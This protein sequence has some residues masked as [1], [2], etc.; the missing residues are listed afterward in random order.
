MFLSTL[1]RILGTITIKEV[2]DRVIIEGIAGHWLA[3]DI[4]KVW[5]TSKINEHMFT[6]LTGSKIVISRFFLLEFVYI[7]EELIATPKISQQTIRAARQLL[8]ELEKSTWLANL[9]EDY[10]SILNKAALANMVLTPKPYQTDFFNQYESN[11]FRLGL[12]GYLLAAPPGSGK[13][14]TS[15]ALM[16]QL[17][18]DA[19]V[20]V[21][22]KNT[23]IDPWENTLKT[24]FKRPY[25]YWT[26]T[27]NKPIT[28]SEK[29][30]V[31]HY[32]YIV[33][34]LE[35]ADK[36]RGRKVGIILDECH[37]LNEINSARTNAFIELCK[38]LKSQHTLWMSGTPIKALGTEVIP[39]L[40]TVCPMFTTDAEERFKKVFG[41]NAKKALDIMAHRLGLLSYRIPKSEIVEGSPIYETIQ[42]T[43]PD[44]KLYTLE[45]I[46]QEMF[47]FM[48]AQMA[49]YKKD[50]PQYV[51][52]FERCLTEYARTLRSDKERADFNEYVRVVSIIR[53][54]VD[55][56]HM[57][58][59]MKLCNDY[60]LGKIIPTLSK[61]SATAFKEVR[62]L[63]KYVQLK[64]R[65]ECLGRV[66]GR[67]RIDCHVAMVEGSTLPV[68]VE[69]ALKK[70][71]IF[72]SFVEVV[73]RTRDY[74]IK[75]GFKPLVVYGDT[76]K[77]IGSILKSY[78]TN[79]EID[80]LIATYKSL[81]TGVPVTTANTIVLMNAPFR[82]YEKEQAISRSFRLGQDTQVY[83]YE[84]FLYTNGEPNISTRS[85]DI[86]EWAQSQI[87]AMMGESPT[88][89]L[90]SLDAAVMESAF[91][92]NPVIDWEKVITDSEHAAIPH[93]RPNDCW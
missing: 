35:L 4:K 7:L 87:D 6:T 49:Y 86:L 21:T 26:S 27:Q 77:D 11:V 60:E 47:D 29:Y 15:L 50:M 69:A 3:A 92:E 17:G 54:T 71:L 74:L 33:K 89:S 22:L 78:A 28:G 90:E 57:S 62:S 25:G 65:G 19:V 23:L 30:Y 41:L 88:V 5:K 79:V 37:N 18:V 72:T 32:E 42:V 48:Q 16:E 82:P 66:L 85:K 12:S 36:F 40:R 91:T 38:A 58:A 81:S 24:G 9:K 31:C 52:V 2:G 13:T 53:K 56:R 43:I 93:N 84:V 63:V 64:V 14:F 8:V 55:L 67:R 1:K 83:V 39:F 70:T 68:I 73:D 75:E 61:E 45:N 34:F 59:E 10:P 46:K 80:P 51:S 44:G 76:N 20:V